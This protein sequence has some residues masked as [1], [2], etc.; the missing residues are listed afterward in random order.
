[1]NSTTKR[2]QKHSADLGIL[3]KSHSKVKRAILKNAPNSLIL[4][5]CDC[6]KEVL[7]GKV[8]V[9][10]REL[11]KLKRHRSV[12]RELG[13]KDPVKTKK[14]LLLKGGKVTQG[15]AALLRT[16]SPPSSSAKGKFRKRLETLVQERAPK[17]P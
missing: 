17:Q 6:A 3:A 2:Q 14:A 8:P 9:S 5:V 13:S 4:A 16:V 1:M 15:L 12:I 10:D 7:E 11:K